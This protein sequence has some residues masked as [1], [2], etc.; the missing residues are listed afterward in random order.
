MGIKTWLGSILIGLASIIILKLTGLIMFWMQYIGL[1]RIIHITRFK[2]K[3]GI[4]GIKNRIVNRN[5]EFRK[6]KKNRQSIKIALG[7][8]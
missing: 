4:G 8:T 2:K 6:Q 3:I 5:N 7:N 1:G